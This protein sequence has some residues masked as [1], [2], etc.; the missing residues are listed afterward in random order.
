M[1][2][3]VTT[4]GIIVDCSSAYRYD[5][6]KDWN[7]KLKI[8]DHTRPFSPLQIILYFRDIKM[9]LDKIKVGDIIYVQYFKVDKYL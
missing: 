9:M 1:D 3:I 4:I 2:P 8:I 6:R 5:L 7:Q